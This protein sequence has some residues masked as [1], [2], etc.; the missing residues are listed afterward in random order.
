[1]TTQKLILLASRD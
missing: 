1:M